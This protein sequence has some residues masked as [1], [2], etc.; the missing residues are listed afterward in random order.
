MANDRIK[1]ARN[2]AS[3]ASLTSSLLLGWVATVRVISERNEGFF[4]GT[5]FAWIQRIPFNGSLWSYLSVQWFKVLYF[6]AVASFIYVVIALFTLFNLP[7]SVGTLTVRNGNYCFHWRTIQRCALLTFALSVAIE[8]MKQ[9]GMGR[10]ELL[11]GENSYVNH[12]V[13]A[14]S[15]I[16]G[17]VYMGRLAFGAANNNDEARLLP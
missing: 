11:A 2:L 4:N 9:R 12:L 1:V 8:I 6:P 13:H 16:L 14:V 5:P 10:L 7:I 15:A 3:T 17:S